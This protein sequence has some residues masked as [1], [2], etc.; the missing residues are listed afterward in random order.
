MQGWEVSPD[1]L[2][3]FQKMESSDPLG[4]TILTTKCKLD[5][6]NGFLVVS[7]NGFAWRIKMGFGQYAAKGAIRAAASSGKSKWVRWCD[8]ADFVPKK[9]G[10]VLVF[11]KIRKNGELKVDKKGNAKTKKWK[12]IVNK[13]KGEEK[14]HFKQR[15][16]AF[17]DILKKLLEQ[18]RP[19]TDPNISDSRI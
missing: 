15:R 10:V 6:E 5:K 16:D 4:E 18:Y 3:M 1:R 14:D 9:A 12:F 13:N 7:E 11:V 8:V 2:D 17:G 19:E